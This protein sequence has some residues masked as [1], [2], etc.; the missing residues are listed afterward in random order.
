[1]KYFSEQIAAKYMK[2]ILSAV[3]YCHANEIV[4]RDLKPE[5]VLF[6]STEEGASLKIIDFGTS[7]KYSKSENMKKLLGTVVKRVSNKQGLLHRARGHQGQ[8]RREVRRM[9][10]R[11]HPLHLALRLPALRGGQQRA[12][13]CERAQGDVLV[14]PGE[15][16]GHLARG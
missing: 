16:S 14:S 5:N 6:A 2:D 11:R 3:A 12:Y 4:H 8:L 10:L 7:R 9:V 13:L 1:M 15:L